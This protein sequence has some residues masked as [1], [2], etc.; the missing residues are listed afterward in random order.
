M[1]EPLQ[2][3]SELETPVPVNSNIADM[4]IAHQCRHGLLSLL[5][6]VNSYY[7]VDELGH[8]HIMFG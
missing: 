5:T 7:C 1:Y 3:D 4:N 2:Q 8:P 6:S